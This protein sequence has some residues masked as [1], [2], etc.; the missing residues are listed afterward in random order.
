MKKKILL[1]S[2]I[3]LSLAL[4]VAVGGTIA[5]L[6]TETND[7]V[8]TFTYGDINIDIKEFGSLATNG[9][10]SF[11]GEDANLKMIPGSDLAKDPSVIVKANSEACWLFVKI[12]ESAN[13]DTFMT[14]AI[15]DGWIALDGV[16]GVYYRA[17]D[18]TTAKAG[19]E[20]PVL[21]DNKVT[22]KTEVTKVMLNGL[23]ESTYPTLAFHAYAVQ[24]ANI[25]DTDNSGSAVDEAWDIAIT[26]LQTP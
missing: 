9:D 2:I 7:I 18:A 20:Y 11:Y 5:Y 21:L 24:Q 16:D 6:F 14:Y 22:V 8:N 13:F 10:L 25:N 3:A 15:A 12:T 26:G 19:A 17:V 23:T 4:L 1:A